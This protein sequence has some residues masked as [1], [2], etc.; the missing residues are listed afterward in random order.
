LVV[1]YEEYRTERTWERGKMWDRVKRGKEGK[2]WRE[3]GEQFHEQ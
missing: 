1:A 3:G 2:S